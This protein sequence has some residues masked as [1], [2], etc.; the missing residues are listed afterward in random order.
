MNGILEKSR[1]LFVLAV[2]VLIGTLQKARKLL[3]NKEGP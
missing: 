1:F 2:R 3:K